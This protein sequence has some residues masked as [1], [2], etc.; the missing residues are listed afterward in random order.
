MIRRINRKHGHASLKLGKLTFGAGYW[1]R[2]FS[3]GFTIIKHSIDLKLGFIWFY[4]DWHQY[5]F[6]TID[7]DWEDTNWDE[8]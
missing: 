1:M 4:I 7:F 6:E 8:D 3:V 2:S 5:N